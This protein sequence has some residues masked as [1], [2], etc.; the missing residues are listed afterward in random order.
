MFIILKEF[1]FPFFLSSFSL[2]SFPRVGWVYVSF[3][4]VGCECEGCLGA[5]IIRIFTLKG[6]ITVLIMM[7]GSRIYLFY[8][9]CFFFHMFSLSNGSCS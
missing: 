7:N 8:I 6:F 3:L 9:L 5:A 2:D 1:F 4:L